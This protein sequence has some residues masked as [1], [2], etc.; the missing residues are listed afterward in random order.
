MNEEV[1][2][3]A[4]VGAPRLS[5]AL[6]RLFVEAVESP[7][8][9]ALLTKVTGDS[10]IR[11]FRDRSAGDAPPLGHVLPHPAPPRS[12]PTR[13]SEAAAGAALGE[14]DVRG[15]MPQTVADFHRAYR[16][17]HASVEEVAEKVIAALAE[18]GRGPS[19]LGWFIASQAEDLRAQARASAERFR[20]G[21]PLGV[22]DGVP[23]AVKDELDQTPYP[24]TGGTMFLGERP[25]EKDA[26]VVA[27]LRAAGALLIG[28]TNMHEVG[29]NPIGLNPH[30]GPSRNPWD[31][32]RIT[33]GSSGGS[34]AAVAG[35]LCPVALG[36]DGGGSIRIPAALCGVVGLKATWGRISERGALPLCW[37]VGHVGPLGATVRD[38]AAAYALIAGTD[39]EDPA[40]AGQPAVHLEG[41]EQP[42]L[43]GIRL[44]IARPWFEDADPD[45]VSRCDEA[46]R[47]LVDV[48][49][50]VVEIP[51]P[52]LNTLL[53]THT[54]LILSEMATT[55]RPYLREDA[56]RFGL[57]V[58]TNL[59]IGQF[60]ESTD[61]VHALRHKFR[62]TREYLRLMQQVDVI[63]TPTTA[64]TASPIPEHALPGGESN[65]PLSDALMRF[66]RVGNLTGF[67]ALA[68][69]CGYDRSGLP[70]SL[71]LLGRP[72]EEPLIL[73]AGRVVERAFERRHPKRLVRL[74]P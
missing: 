69:P 72:W 32:G 41:F 3:R 43:E 36:A 73:R 33:G 70:V 18:A 52:D 31:P 74:L 55:L 28:K 12:P 42:A 61:Y 64:A 60:F 62:L 9:A 29:I 50:T 59:A 25:A 40:T 54:V 20:A 44:G 34:A 14:P 16:E 1:Y 63:V 65:L 2:R 47:A 26:T 51:S 49:A 53:W 39:P 19:P 48:G 21:R 6:L 57:D 35:G 46:V 45:V 4:P 7:L 17:G 10:G 5:G 22:F 66:V 11:S 30:H 27:H 37:T 71:Q 67:P 13:R 8:G 58:R 56:R 38:V 68:V 23:V 15:A 24:T